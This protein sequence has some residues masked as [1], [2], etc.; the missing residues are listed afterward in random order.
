MK[1][2]VF[3]LFLVFV[4]SCDPADLR[5]KFINTVDKE[6]YVES[7]SM[8]SINLGNWVQELEKFYLDYNKDIKD[9][10]LLKNDTII[11]PIIG[12]WEKIL[13][14]TSQYVSVIV[15]DVDYLSS[16]DSIKL[17]DAVFVYKLNLNDIKKLNWEIKFSE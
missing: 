4:V 13:R 3:L 7:V 11:L 5:L 1:N 2:I 15:L 6:I 8:D 10:V 12:D 9:D 17:E 16:K 14:D